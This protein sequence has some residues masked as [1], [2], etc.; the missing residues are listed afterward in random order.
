MVIQGRLRRGPWEKSAPRPAEKEFHLIGQLGS[1]GYRKVLKS[2]AL[3]S[4]LQTG[5][6]E[7]WTFLAKVKARVRWKDTVGIWSLAETKA[8]A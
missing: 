8:Q 7:A 6:A 5:W 1:G 3:V 4:T 2:G